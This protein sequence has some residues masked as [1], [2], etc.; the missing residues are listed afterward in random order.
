VKIVIEKNQRIYKKRLK[1]S[2]EKEKM[3]EK[4]EIKCQFC[5]NTFNIIDLP[6]RIETTDIFLGLNWGIP[7]WEEYRIGYCP[8]CMFSL[9]R[10]NKK[11]EYKI[12]T[13]L[14]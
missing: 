12:N 7:S 6:I 9:T 3:S 4:E 13:K 2:E 14:T 5:G 10:N 11:I 1:K 8:I